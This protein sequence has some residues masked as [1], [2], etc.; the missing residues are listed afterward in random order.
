[1]GRSACAEYIRDVMRALGAEKGI[2][3]DTVVS[4]APP[5][6]EN[7]YGAHGYRCP[8]GLIYWVEPTSEQIAEWAEQQVP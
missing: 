3:C 5:I 7:P 6:V 8:H 4:T 2:G 1:M